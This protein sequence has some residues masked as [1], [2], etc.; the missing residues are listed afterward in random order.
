MRKK[1]ILGSV[2]VALLMLVSTQMVFFEIVRSSDPTA[3][4]GYADAGDLWI[5]ELDVSSD[6]ATFDYLGIGHA[7]ATDDW[8]IWENGTGTINSYWDVDIGSGYHP[9]YYVLLH[10]VLYNVDDDN[11]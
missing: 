2:L 1:I 5:D 4:E 10:M 11:A 6:R 7:N 8:V 9:E 3:H